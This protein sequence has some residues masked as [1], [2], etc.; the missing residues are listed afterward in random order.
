MVIY[1]ILN[2]KNNKRYIGQSI[3]KKPQ[4]RWFYHRWTLKNNSHINSHLQRAWNKYGEK[5]FCW[6]IICKCSSLTELNN[7]ETKYINMYKNKNLCYNMTKG[8]DNALLSAS[9]KKKLSVSL[10]KYYKNKGMRLPPLI[11]PE[12]V[13][14]SNIINLTS[15][16]RDKSLRRDR[17]KKLFRGEIEQHRGWRLKNPKKFGKVVIN[18]K[19]TY[20]ITSPD[21]KKYETKNLHQFIRDM[22]FSKTSFQMIQYPYNR[23]TKYQGWKIVKHKN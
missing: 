14:H 1:E 15:F 7:K 5:S 6:T 21:G 10:K 13:A 18:G 11:S 20:I 9:S 17:M 23:G 8:G 16:C 22:G 3:S 4:K 12:G 19:Y 2:I